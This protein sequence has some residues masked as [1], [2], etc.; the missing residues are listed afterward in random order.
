MVD[1]FLYMRQIVVLDESVTMVTAVIGRNILLRQVY[2]EYIAMS[3]DTSV[4]W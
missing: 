2:A 3:L 1:V 4:T